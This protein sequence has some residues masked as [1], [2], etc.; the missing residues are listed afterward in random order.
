MPGT[1]PVPWGVTHPARLSP[2]PEPQ[3]ASARRQS[4]DDLLPGPGS[5][6]H[7]E[8][9]ADLT[10]WDPGGS[11]C[12]DR[13]TK[14]LVRGRGSAAAS[15]QVLHRILSPAFPPPQEHPGFAP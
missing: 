2:E 5:L 8:N 4:V 9:P 15:K 1:I 13:L 12:L 11:S 14:G 7:S 6:R 3:L 10:P